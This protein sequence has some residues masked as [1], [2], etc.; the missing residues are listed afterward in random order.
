MNEDSD[1]FEDVD[2]VA[3]RVNV[4]FSILR[5][6]EAV[7][8]TETTRNEFINGDSP[9]EVKFRVSTPSAKTVGTGVGIHSGGGIPGNDQAYR[10]API[11]VTGVGGDRLTEN[12]Q[13]RQTIAGKVDDGT[14]IPSSEAKA[15]RGPAHMIVEQM[16][17]G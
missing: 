7:M 17:K 11:G 5:I 2:V 15:P 9:H 16:L 10:L 13:F 6:V 3:V 4:R 14:L 1:E 8:L 12:S